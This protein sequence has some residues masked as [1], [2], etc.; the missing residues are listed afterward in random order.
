MREAGAQRAV[1]ADCWRRCR[2]MQ[3]VGGF[4]VQ[5]HHPAAL[6]LSRIPHCGN[7]NP[8]TSCSDAHVCLCHPARCQQ[9]RRA[10]RA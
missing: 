5:A 8:K 3:F 1:A 9:R 2:C 4:Q 10:P 6:T 7:R